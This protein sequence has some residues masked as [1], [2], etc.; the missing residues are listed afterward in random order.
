MND[1][2]GTPASLWLETAPSTDY[3]ALDRDMTVDVAVLGGG[4]AGL[5]TALM[6]ARSGA[7][8]AVLDAGRVGRGVSG[9]STAKV[10]SLHSLTYA[11]LISSRGEDHAH[12]YGEA[13][14]AGLATI[15]RYARELAI[16]CDF[17]RRP[18][19]TYTESPEEVDQVR[20]EAESA[21]GV[22]L[23]SSFVQGQI[24]LPWDVQG[25]VR[26]EDQAEFHPCKYLVG[27]AQAV[28]GAGGQIY[29]GT[30]AVA[31]D[32]GEQCT[33]H[34]EN[35]REVRAG[36]VVVAT[37]FPFLDRSGFFA[38]IHP[39]RSYVLA[40]RIRGQVPQGMYI[41]TQG[42]SLRSQPAP[43]GGELLLVGGASHKV[44]QADEA[45]Q[46]RHLD[47][48]AR[49]RFEVESIDYRWS[50]QDNIPLDKVPYVGKLAPF[51][52]RVLVA[53]GFRKW[54]YANGT[55][56]AI[57]LADAVKGREHPWASTFD[58]S[59]LGPPS[60]AVP[61][62]KEN[63]NVGRRFVQDRLKRGSAEAVPPGEGAIVRDGLH[64]AAVHRADNGDLHALSA[65][66]TH[67]GCIVQWNTAER[68]WDCPCHGSRFGIDGRVL[69]GPAVAPLEPRKL[70]APDSA[71]VRE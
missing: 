33:V 5:T 4:I 20:E 39:E 41:D 67:L 15:A 46:Y 22:G 36:H 69:Q 17:R 25:A 37:H 52:K 55:A 62:V 68:S 2:P 32:D 64:Q 1:L 51:S 57:M 11:D 35:G 30:R 31:V 70:Q 24:G 44:G 6:L 65:R 63:A 3:P 9:Y 16:D 28:R 49:E 59:R 66:C 42:H 12:V 56:A 19:F 18:N 53:T 14:E 60:A 54:G 7:S 40:V 47:R 27:I 71:P 45:E 13:N 21:A 26:F 38:R 61:F 34:A 23:P 10:T 58:S 43:G 50:T 48:Y 8:V 29:E